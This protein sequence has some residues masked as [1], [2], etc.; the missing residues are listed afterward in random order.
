MGR[1]KGTDPR[2]AKDRSPCSQLLKRSAGSGPAGVGEVVGWSGSHVA[3]EAR[4]SLLFPVSGIVGSDSRAGAKQAEERML[5]GIDYDA[6]MAAPDGQ[7]AGLRI[8]HTLKFVN[9]GVEV[10]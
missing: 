3:E 7:V 8:G 6:G 1:E 9:A 2:E 4:V 10:R 5:R